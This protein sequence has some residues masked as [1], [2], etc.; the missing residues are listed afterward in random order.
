M[1]FRNHCLN[2]N[3][4]LCALYTTQRHKVVRQSV[5]IHTEAEDIQIDDGVEYNFAVCCLFYTHL[6]ATSIIHS[7]HSLYCPNRASLNFPWERQHMQFL[8][9]YL[10]LAFT[11]SLPQ[12]CRSLSLFPGTHSKQTVISST[13]DKFQASSC[14][15]QSSPEWTSTRNH[16]VAISHHL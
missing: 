15:L 13:P 5:M 9:V 14:L 11:L 7:S 16:G 4:D 6:S 8:Y 2:N 3:S 12:L 10:P 1:Q